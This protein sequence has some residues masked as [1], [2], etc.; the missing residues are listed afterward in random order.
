MWCNKN[1]FFNGISCQENGCSRLLF[2]VAVVETKKWTSVLS[3]LCLINEYVREI[4]LE[5]T[6]FDC[7]A[8]AI[9]HLVAFVRRKKKCFTYFTEVDSSLTAVPQ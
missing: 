9:S 5:I 2:F 8:S 1:T 3:T 4:L 6:F 7:L